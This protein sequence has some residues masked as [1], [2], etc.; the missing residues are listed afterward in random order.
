MS[1]PPAAPSATTKDAT[2]ATK[3]G[4]TSD[5]YQIFTAL[6]AKLDSLHLDAHQ[7]A[8]I[9][10]AKENLFKE[11]QSS[12]LAMTHILDQIRSNTS[13]GTNIESSSEYVRLHKL[14]QVLKEKTATYGLPF[15]MNT[16]LIT[17][18]NY[19]EEIVKVEDKRWYLVLTADALPERFTNEWYISDRYTEDEHS[20][21]Y[22][23][24]KRELHGWL[25]GDILVNVG[26]IIVD[27]TDLDVMPKKLLDIV[28]AQQ[29]YR[30]ALENAIGIFV[31]LPGCGDYPMFSTRIAHVKQ[32]M[33]VIKQII[34][35]DTNPFEFCY[36]IFVTFNMITAYPADFQKRFED[37]FFQKMKNGD[38]FTFD[39]VAKIITDNN[40]DDQC[41][42]P[43]QHNVNAATV[44]SS[45]SSA[46]TVPITRPTSA[47]KLRKPVTVPW[48]H[49]PAP[50]VVA[51][52]PIIPSSAISTSDPSTTSSM[53]QVL[54]NI[55]SLS[56]PSSLTSSSEIRMR[57][58]TCNINHPQNQH[59]IPP[60][61]MK[62]AFK[63]SSDYYSKFKELK[64]LE[65]VANRTARLD[66]S[67]ATGAAPSS[68][69]LTT[70][71]SNTPN[72]T[73]L[74]TLLDSGASISLLP[75]K[76][77]HLAHLIAPTSVVIQY[78]NNTQYHADKIYLFIVRIQDVTV[79]VPAILL[80]ED[81][82][83]SPILSVHSVASQNLKI[84]FVL[85]K[86]YLKGV[87]KY[88]ARYIDNHYKAEINLVPPPNVPP[89]NYPVSSV[90][91]PA[92]GPHFGSNEPSTSQYAASTS[93]DISN[94]INDQDVELGLYHNIAPRQPENSSANPS[95]PV[96][97]INHRMDAEV[98]TTYQSLYPE[99]ELLADYSNSPALQYHNNTGHPS[100]TTIKNSKLFKLTANDVKYI[101]NCPTCNYTK[102]HKNNRQ[103]NDKPQVRTT[104]PLQCVHLDTTGAYTAD[105]KTKWYTV[106]IVDDFT[107]Y[108]KSV[109]VTK[110]GMIQAEVRKVLTEWS[111]LK[112][113]PVGSLKSDNGSEF[114]DLS[115]DY[116]FADHPDYTPEH[117]SIVE[118]QIGLLKQ[119]V[120]TLMYPFKDNRYAVD[121]LYPYATRYA[122]ELRN[123]WYHSTIDGIP[124][125]RFTGKMPKLSTTMPLFGSDIWIMYKK[126]KIPAIFIGYKNESST[127][128]CL[129]LTY[130][131][132]EVITNTLSEAYTFHGAYYLLNIL[133][134]FS[135]LDK[136]LHLLPFEKELMPV[137]KRTSPGPLLAVRS[138]VV[139]KDAL[140]GIVLN[141]AASISV[142]PLDSRNSYHPSIPC[143]LFMPK[144][145]A[146]CALAQ[147]LVQI[148]KA[149]TKSQSVQQKLAMPY[150]ATEEPTASSVN[151][152]K[153]SILAPP[154][155]D[156]PKSY[157][158]A[159]KNPHFEASIL[160]EIE[161]FMKH[162][163]FLPV[164]NVEIMN[165]KKLPDFQ[166][167]MCI[168]LFSVKFDEYSAEH[169]C[170]ARLVALGNRESDKDIIKASPS[171]TPYCFRLITKIAVNNQWEIRSAD[172][173]TAFL[174]S[175]LE[176]D[177]YVRVP[178]GF[179]SIFP[180]TK[181]LKVNKA[182]Y[183][184]SDSN[185]LFALTVWKTLT[186]FVGPDAGSMLVQNQA[187]VCSFSYIVNGELCGCVGIYC[188]DF[189]QTGTKKFLDSLNEFLSQHFTLKIKSYPSTFLGCE[190]IYSNGSIM[191]H[192]QKYIEK[193][194]N[195][196]GWNSSMIRP[197]YSPA[198]VEMPSSWVHD[199]LAS[200]N[201][202]PNEI[203]KLL[204]ALI[205]LSTRTRP[206]LSYY[207]STYATMPKTALTLAL[208][209]YTLRYVYTTRDYGIVIHPEQ[210]CKLSLFTD[211]S[212][213]M[214]TQA[215]GVVFYGS[216][217]VYWSSVKKQIYA[218]G[219][220]VNAEMYALHSLS[221]TYLYIAGIIHYMTNK[222]YA[223]PYQVFIDNKPLIH[224]LSGH[225][226]IEE[227]PDRIPKYYEL[228]SW[229]NPPKRLL[230][231]N[232]IAGKNNPAD[233]F[234]KVL[235]TATVQ[236]YRSYLNLTADITK[237]HQLESLH[238]F[239]SLQK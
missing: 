17:Q 166:I 39:D 25:I 165:L 225:R 176:R 69:S 219:S 183:G 194:M 145:S 203:L 129:T 36:T 169:I 191:L 27:P 151:P 100:L 201:A 190:L 33:K 121:M 187:D 223:Y 55:L 207:V 6:A 95:D 134:S 153:S 185:F 196:L 224:K 96:I 9:K 93:A 200:K 42:A 172:V 87:Q 12:H 60:A 217:P 174:N 74:N 239:T 156:I 168:W 66:T 195:K 171:L 208:I 162:D 238:E 167:L 110:K 175:P 16:S 29:P 188:D 189:Y 192:Q 78:A 144:I 92:G 19:L 49:S 198:P 81:K 41:A 132:E 202:D 109:T 105:N 8:V 84:S 101:V 111:L 51:A 233:L 20:T 34:P 77:A 63:V 119:I 43:V 138:A 5:D 21:Y 142:H 89:T 103:H 229:F 86:A 47:Y 235:P 177:V 163:V 186:E 148:C 124:A 157:K 80:P 210:N 182:V 160:L 94:L 123:R 68:H 104:R 228:K 204:G 220:T 135:S 83:S 22:N 23:K 90:R 2:S 133:I 11:T 85:E 48:I 197:A 216:T 61:I 57:C 230:K 113:L 75:L 82:L 59:I 221:T 178:A 112:A 44:A 18:R 232:H 31:E 158:Q 150:S 62:Q 7:A 159:V 234:T 97:P 72:P 118:R 38:N 214:T 37:A 149:T 67:A 116:K 15:L 147:P 236:Q 161:Q 24:L 127:Y 227:I 79:Q 140:P 154:I 73:V 179:E 184:L 107:R 215:G 170:K 71:Q 70:K 209:R 98:P 164:S 226:Q 222:D 32:I 139:P 64:K 155:F 52:A 54:A 173:K 102:L 120:A 212:L 65:Q 1:P 122:A 14:R 88:I 213:K 206:D 193:L 130:P 126:K 58:R 46:G 136:F 137:S 28:V 180:G 3:S 56:P 181:L 4:F 237:V 26:H 30:V 99:F 218:D 131:C 115:P 152:K 141:V 50:Q 143:E 76:Y 53:N 146:C 35:K 114:F 231:L 199:D 45:L 117:N 128:H 13:R 91:V 211:A 108:S 125:E 106:V 10:K 205:W 40:L